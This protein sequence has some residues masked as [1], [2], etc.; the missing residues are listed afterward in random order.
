[1]TCRQSHHTFLEHSVHHCF[2]RLS[3]NHALRTNRKQGCSGS[4]GLLADE[5]K[6]VRTARGGHMGMEL[7]RPAPMMLWGAEAAPV[8]NKS[9]WGMG[10]RGL[11]PFPPPGTTPKGHPASLSCRCTT[12]NFPFCPGL[13]PSRPT[14]VPCRSLCEPV[15]SALT[16]SAF[17]CGTWEARNQPHWENLHHGNWQTANQDSS[18]PENSR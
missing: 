5:E 8:N 17:R 4:Q 7:Q 10:V 6:E 11:S 3:V 12:V 16:T 14:A 13:S 15:P 2:I 9:T 18:P 1:M